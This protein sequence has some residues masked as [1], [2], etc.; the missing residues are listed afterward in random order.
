MTVVVSAM[1]V[2][3]MVAVGWSIVDVAR[4][5]IRWAAAD[6]SPKAD[7]RGSQSAV[8]F[9]SLPPLGPVGQLGGL[10]PDADIDSGGT[11]E[12]DLYGC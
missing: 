2:V 1:V 9:G 10:S 5:L 3:A 4:R 8:P 6:S 7:V 11:S 12:H